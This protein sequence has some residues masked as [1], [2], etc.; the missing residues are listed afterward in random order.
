MFGLIFSM[1]Q[2]FQG[3]VGTN[4]FGSG[5]RLLPLIGGLIIGGAAADRL[6]HGAGAK[7][8]VALVRLSWP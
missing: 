7:L 8:T 2:Y 5:L 1:P 4:A 3:V 6:A